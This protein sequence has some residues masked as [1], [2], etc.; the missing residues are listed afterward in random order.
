MT[1]KRRL[2]RD[3]DLSLA[4]ERRIILSVTGMPGSGKDE[5]IKVAKNFGFQDYHMGDTVRT[6]AHR[7]SIPISDSEIGKFAS[8]EREK[9]GMN[10]WARRTYD[11]IGDH[12]LFII[13]GIRNYE[14]A[15]YFSNNVENFS[16]IAI[17]ANRITRL[18]RI[19]KRNRADDIHDMEGLIARDNREL[20][21]GIGKVIALSDYMIVND[22]TLD[23]FRRKSTSLIKTIHDRVL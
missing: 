6:Y 5:F 9:H 12:K 11:L 4:N 13:D 14:E 10:I 1:R 20:N 18:E 3:W 21:W 19:L 23:E 2:T 22:S 16:I 15:E 8:G 7:S 17:F